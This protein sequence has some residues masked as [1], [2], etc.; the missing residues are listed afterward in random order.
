MVSVQKTDTGQFT[1]TFFADQPDE[2]VDIGFRS[3]FH[4]DGGVKF[5]FQTLFGNGSGRNVLSVQIVLDSPERQCRNTAS[6]G[7]QLED[8][9]GQ[10]GCTSFRRYVCGYQY[11][12]HDVEHFIRY[13]ISDQCLIDEMF[14]TQE[15]FFGQGMAV[16]QQGHDVEMEKR[17]ENDIGFRFRSANNGL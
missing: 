17:T 1:Q 3:H 16:C 9:D 14:R 7:Y 6:T 10:F 15:G 4:T 12:L 5:S 11:L 8:G 2:V 13:G